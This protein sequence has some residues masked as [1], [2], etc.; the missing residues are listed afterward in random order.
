MQHWNKKQYVALWD[1]GEHQHLIALDSNMGMRSD[2]FP[3][4]ID[5]LTT[6]ETWIKSL[7]LEKDFNG[8]QAKIVPLIAQNKVNT[9]NGFTDPID[10]RQVA[11]FLNDH[12]GM[13]AEKVP[14]SKTNLEYIASS[15]KV[16]APKGAWHECLLIA[17][18]Y[19]K[20]IQKGLL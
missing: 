19:K 15:L 7:K 5:S 2:V 20:L 17:N 12:A 4:T 6:L 8:N 10:I 11:R 13:H 9:L 18:S 16:E 1:D 14:F 3:T